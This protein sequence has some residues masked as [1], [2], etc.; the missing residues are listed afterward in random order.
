MVPRASRISPTTAPSSNRNSSGQP[1]FV[2]SALDIVAEGILDVVDR[3]ERKNLFLEGYCDDGSD[4][5]LITQPRPNSLRWP[6]LEVEGEHLG[7]TFDF[8][9]VAL[10]E[11]IDRV[12]RDLKIVTR[13]EI[14]RRKI[15]NLCSRLIAAL[16]VEAVQR[17]PGHQIV[18]AERRNIESVSPMRA[19]VGDEVGYRH[20][21]AAVAV[22][23][24]IKS[25]GTLLRASVTQRVHGTTGHVR[26]SRRRSRDADASPRSGPRAAALAVAE[27][28]RAC[29]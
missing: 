12:I 19:S 27:A 16:A 9:G 15:G 22:A 13:Q 17:Q 14:G 20:R 6:D 11:R 10:D 29:S 26:C 21:N 2:R 8:E 28:L 7:G 5:D 25:A 1:A 4:A 18:E 23:T 24:P 3:A